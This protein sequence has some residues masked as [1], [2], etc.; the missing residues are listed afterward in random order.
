MNRLKLRYGRNPLRP[1]RRVLVVTV[2][3]ERK[4][5]GLLFVQAVLRKAAVKGA[6]ADS[7]DRASAALASADELERSD[8]K[9]P[10]DLAQC[11]S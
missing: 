1:V 9:F 6:A 2:V 10:L 11:R 4:L 5:F 3:R 8:N 7:E